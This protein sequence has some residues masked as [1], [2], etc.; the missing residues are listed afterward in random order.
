[1]TLA[2]A[3]IMA[4]AAYHRIV[5]Q[6][7]VSQFFVSFLSWMIAAAMVPLMVALCLEV[8]LIGV[9]IL[10]DRAAAATIASALLLVFAGLWFAFPFGM[11]IQR[12]L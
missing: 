2:I 5:E 10:V 3:M 7:S 4:P 12:R 11:R 1:V 9:I 6:G 8:F